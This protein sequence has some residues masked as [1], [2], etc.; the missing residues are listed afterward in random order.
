MPKL[1]N[2]NG[3]D[4]YNFMLAL[5][6]FLQNRGTV[7]VEEA[8]DHFEVDAKY[9][10]KVVT[11]INDA[12]ATLKDFEEWFFLIDVEAFEEEGMLTLL[13]NDLIDEVPKLSNRQASAIAAGLNYLAT[14]PG[15]KDDKDLKQ[16]QAFLAAGGSRG[17]NPLI[18]RGISELFALR[19]LP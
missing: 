19:S 15:F 6:A 5:V 11:S 1:K 3:E 12:R 9:L 17:I 7:S 8:A 13:K 10:R 16:L 14:I 4:R 18:E 2:F